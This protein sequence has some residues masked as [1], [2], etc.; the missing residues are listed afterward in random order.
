[1]HLIGLGLLELFIAFGISK[2]FDRI[3]HA[4]LLQKLHS[5]R[6][7]GLS[8]LS[9]RQLQVVLT[10]KKIYG[11]YLWMGFNCLKARA[12]LRRQFTFYH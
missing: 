2:V 11:P 12:T 10:L 1:M 5:H 6:V 4:G 7:A 3:W 8:L 9:N